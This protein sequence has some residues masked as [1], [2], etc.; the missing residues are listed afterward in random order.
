[1]S[2]RIVISIFFLAVGVLAEPLP[3]IP[4]NIYA[5]KTRYR[6]NYGETLG[7]I[8]NK[9]KVSVA[10]LLTLNEDIYDPNEI[11]A[12]QFITVPD[13]DAIAKI[14]ELSQQHGKLLI[15]LGA[16]KYPERK[17]A[18]KELIR[19]DWQ[20]VPLLLEALKNPDPEVRENAREVLRALHRRKE[21]VGNSNR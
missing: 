3:E 20:V 6:I 4:E 21:G 11:Y 17:K 18:I 13:K 5:E 2:K 7:I 8:A 14:Q 15:Q 16:E 10:F 9:H 12:D 1:M 19:L